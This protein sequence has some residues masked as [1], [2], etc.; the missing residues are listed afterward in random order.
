MCICTCT[1]HNYYMASNSFS[2]LRAFRAACGQG[3]C[4]ALQQLS[5]QTGLP[6]PGIQC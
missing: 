2:E 1:S 4:E 6:Y 5:F 3:A